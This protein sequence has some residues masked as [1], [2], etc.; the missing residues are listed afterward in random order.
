[1]VDF[2]SFGFFDKTSNKDRTFWGSSEVRSRRHQQLEEKVAELEARLQAKWIQMCS[3]PNDIKDMCRINMCVVAL[4]NIEVLVVSIYGFP[5]N[6]VNAKRYTDI[7]LSH[8]YQVVTAA[9]IPYIIGGDFNVRPTDL[10]IFEAFHNLGAVEMFQVVQA[11]LG[12]TLPHTC[13]GVTSHDTCK[14]HPALAQRLTHAFVCQKQDFDSHSPLCFELDIRQKILQ[15]L[16]WQIPKSWKDFDLHPDNLQQ[17]YQRQS[18]DFQLSIDSI[19]SS[20]TGEE[21]LQQWSSIVERSVDQTLRIQHLA[22]PLRNPVA[23]LPKEY[24]G[25]CK[26]RVAQEKSFPKRP[27]GDKFNGYNPPVECLLTVNR[28]KTRQ[29]RRLKSYQKA[30]QS[31]ISKGEIL[32]AQHSNWKQLV[33]EWQV[34]CNAKGYSRAWFHWILAFEPIHCVPAFLPAMELLDLCIEITKCDCDASC[35][36]EVLQ[37]QKRFAYAVH[38]DNTENFGT[39]TYKY[40]KNQQTPKLEEVPYVISQ[41]ATLCRS[42]KGNHT[43]RL[44]QPVSFICEQQASFGDANIHLLKQEQCF[45]TFRI[46]DGII[47]STG[48]LRHHRITTTAPELFHEFEKHWKPFWM[49][50]TTSEQFDSSAWTDFMLELEKCPMPQLHIPIVLDDVRLWKKAIKKLKPRKAEGVCG[51]RHEELQR[52]PDEAIEHLMMIFNRLWEYGLT[53]NMMQ[54]RTILLSKVSKP[55]S[56]GHGRPITILSVLY[57]LASKIIF[58][59]AGH[60][61]INTFHLKSPEDFQHVELGIWF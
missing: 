60:I 51:W 46:L 52:L 42:T 41:N 21:V 35:R 50:D 18:R 58:E 24:C 23:N 28:L 2:L 17:S 12:F 43:L 32:N 49:R 36:Q 53:H 34:I 3:G 27:K 40:M 55:T 11:K 31:I 47:P 56:I 9:K 15:P 45:I 44:E 61:G 30:R 37:R 26:T 4:A 29:V 7:L 57:R 25:R 10:P 59:Q 48:I 8:I 14:L 5:S 22:D 20:Q 33:G 16:Q 13:R 1:M 6:Y 19:V 38:I 39:I 54:A